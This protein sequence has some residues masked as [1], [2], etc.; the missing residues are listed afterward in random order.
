MGGE[1]CHLENRKIKMDRKKGVSF[2]N[3]SGIQGVWKWKFF[4]ILLAMVGKSKK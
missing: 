2:H 3:R 4:H 1:K